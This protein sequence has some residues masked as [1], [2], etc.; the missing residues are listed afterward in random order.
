MFKHFPFHK[1]RDAMDCGSTCLMMIADY[2]GKH[3]SLPY[4]R[5][6]CHLSR[7]GVSVEKKKRDRLCQIST[8]Q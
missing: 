4:L 1:Q 3:Y 8:S 6:L 2:H 5:E 7:E